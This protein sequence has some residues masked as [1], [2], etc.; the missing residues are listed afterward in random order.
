MDPEWHARCAKANRQVLVVTERLVL[1]F[2]A[3][4]KGGARQG[5]HR[6]VLAP[7][8]DLAR[9]QERPISHW[10][11]RGWPI[12]VFLRSAIYPLVQQ[13]ATRAP[14]DHLSHFV[15]TARV[16]QDPGSPI[17][18]EYLGLPTQAF[19]D[20][21]ADVQVEADFDVVPAIDLPHAIT[22]RV[23]SYCR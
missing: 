1:R 3:A 17:E 19:A 13:R 7:D 2:A 21:D 14:A 15:G 6:A 12:R 11:D 20:V 10:R 8:L 16:R 23:K 22:I 5:L 4:A 18:L 9:H